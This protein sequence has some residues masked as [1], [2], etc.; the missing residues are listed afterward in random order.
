M[1]EQSLNDIYHDE[2]ARKYRAGSA[3]C[4]RCAIRPVCGG[5]LAVNYGFGNDIFNDLD[6]YCWINK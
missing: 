1:F 3:S 2:P 5:C 4:S 6:P